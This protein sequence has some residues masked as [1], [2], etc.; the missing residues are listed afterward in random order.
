[1]EE[2]SGAWVG[3]GKVIKACRFQV[4]VTYTG[5]QVRCP[6]QIHTCAQIDLLSSPFKHMREFE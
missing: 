4:R 6:I 1:M 2:G 5:F 3:L